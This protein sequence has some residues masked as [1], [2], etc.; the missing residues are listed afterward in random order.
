LDIWVFSEKFSTGSFLL[1][2]LKRLF[3][4]LFPFPP[5]AGDVISSRSRSPGAGDRRGGWANVKIE[6]FRSRPYSA[7]IHSYLSSPPNFSHRPRWGFSRPNSRRE[8]ASRGSD[9]RERP[10]LAEPRGTGARHERP[11]RGAAAATAGSGGGTADRASVLC[12]AC[13]PS[14]WSGYGQF[15]P[16]STGPCLLRSFGGRGSPKSGSRSDLSFAS[17]EGC[18]EFM[19]SMGAEGR[20]LRGCN[21]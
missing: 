14:G 10:R 19:G 4:Q 18:P 7:T 20:V 16:R 3:R 11:F 2:L 13:H 6:C 21:K 15:A 1:V 8:G 9:R 12:G 5:G 17:P